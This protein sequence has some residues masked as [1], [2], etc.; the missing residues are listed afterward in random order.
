MDDGGWVRVFEP[1]QP[2]T[3][4]LYVR[5]SPDESGLRWRPVEMH[6][7][8]API[9]G[10]ILRRLPLAAI[11]ALAARAEIRE[12]IKRRA[13]RPLPPAWVPWDPFRDV[14]LSAKESLAL[15]SEP[16]NRGTDTAGG[17]PADEPPPPLTTPPDGRLTDEFLR[18]VAQN[19][20]AAVG[21]RKYPAPTLAA[22]A[23]VSA[24]T[25][26]RWVYTAR[27]RGIMH[28]TKQGKVSC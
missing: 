2:P 4:A 11:E 18:S 7:F 16:L 23:G 21:A 6:L 14:H 22:Q 19:Y 26:Q 28:Q 1:A 9:T 20:A 24:R 13:S 15:N 3:G 8:G 17:G 25:V 27:Q 12:E 5:F 10:R